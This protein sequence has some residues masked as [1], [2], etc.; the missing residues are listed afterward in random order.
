[1]TESKQ[2]SA[3]PLSAE[4]LTEARGLLSRY[5]LGAA[6]HTVYRLLSAYE[7]VVR[8]RDEL[9]EKIRKVGAECWESGFVTASDGQ[10]MPEDSDKADRDR[11]VQS[12]M[13]DSQC[14]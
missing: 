4:E 11:C 9:R 2:E 1:M 14:D 12:W 13:E 7:S 6:E 3:A 10:F 5:H 8:E